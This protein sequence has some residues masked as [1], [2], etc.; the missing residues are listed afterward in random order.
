M[1]HSY[2]FG[3]QVRS[4]YLLPV[5]L[6]MAEKDEEVA[7]LQVE[8]AKIN[9]VLRLIHNKQLHMMNVF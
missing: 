3:M 4:M 6:C 5:C 1:E 2:L 9:R 7:A 8:S